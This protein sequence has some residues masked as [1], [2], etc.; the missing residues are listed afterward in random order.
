MK[1]LYLDIETNL[2]HSVIWCVGYSVDGAAPKVTRYA[3]EVKDLIA[4]AEMVVG[5][6]IVGFDAPV[7]ERVWGVRKPPKKLQDTMLMSRLHNPSLDGGHSLAAWGQR[8]HCPKGDF[9][10]YDSGYCAEMDMYCR[11]DVQVTIQLHQHL[12][13]ALKNEDFSDDSITLERNV[14]VVV[15]KQVRRGFYFDKPA[16]ESLNNTVLQR[17]S[18]IEAQFQEM[19][20]PRMVEMWSIATKKPLKPYLDVFNLGSRQQV[21]EKLFEVGVGNQLTD[22]TPSGRYKLS[23]EVLS[24]VD[25]PEAKLVVDYLTLQKRTSQIVQWLKY[26]TDEGRIHG[27]VI[28]NGAVTRRMTHHSPNLAQVPNGGA[29]LGPEC[30]ELFKPALGYVLVGVDASALELCMLAHYMK[31]GDFTYSVVSGT[32]EAGTDVHTRNQTM[33]GLRS[34]DEAKTFI[35]AFLYGAGAAKIGAIVGGGATDGHAL[36]TRFLRSLPNL[37]ALKSKVERMAESG[38]LPGLDGRR[39]RVRSAHS[40]L[41]TLLQSAG[42]IVMKKALVILHN[43]IVR[44]K[45]DAHFTGNIHDEYQLEVKPEQAAQ[46]AQLGIDAIIKAGVEL[47]LRC[48]LNGEA[49]I[50]SSWKETH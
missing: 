7:L 34:R 4:S 24:T 39:L 35:Y 23:E 41:N 17:M 46:V 37:A 3:Q 48:P 6:N 49:N 16:G 28:T 40:S 2:A 25:I 43:D 1:T 32:K 29:Y 12:I 10:D 21:V 19:F 38:M 45:L 26:C 36:I 13:K 11:N 9:T 30:R 44:N 20:P 27:K 18:E 50:G 5:H 14:A 15:E 31:D 22:R 47:G 42:A 8:L 33:A